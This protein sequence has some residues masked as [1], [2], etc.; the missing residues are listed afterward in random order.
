[1]SAPGEVS[2]LTTVFNLVKLALL[3]FSSTLGISTRRL[4][5][6]QQKVENINDLVSPQG[7]VA[8]EHVVTTKDGYL[9]VVHK[10]EKANNEVGGSGVGSVHSGAPGSGGQ[11]V[12][13]HHGL[14]TNSEL[15]VL[16]TSKEKTLPFL[17]VDM[18][19]E[20]WLGN[21]RGN[22]YS[23]K[24]LKLSS[25]S[26]EFWD[27][28]LDEFAYFD[29]PDT[30]QYIQDYSSYK[31]SCKSQ[32]QLFDYMRQNFE[33][34]S[35]SSTQC[36]TPIPHFNS[37]S[38]LLSGTSNSTG[39]PREI[40]Y[41]GFSQGCSQ[42]IA[43]LALYP[44]LNGKIKQF[45]G[46]SPAIVPTPSPNAIVQLVVE[47]TAMDNSFLYSLFGH[48]AIL[49]S[50]SFWQMMFGPWLYTK[51]VDRSLVTLFGWTGKNISPQQKAKGY[52]YMFSNTSVKSLIHWFQILHAGRFQMFEE[53]GGFGR[54]N[55]SCISNHSKLKGTRVT[56]FPISDHLDVPFM[57]FC[58]DKDILVDADVTR[59]LIVD[60]N[61]KMKDQLEIVMCPG[62]E[63]MDTLWGDEVFQDVF[64][65]ILRKLEDL[66]GKSGA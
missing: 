52:P 12:Y 50:V 25:L 53:T 57:L 66:E 42:L 40:I 6:Q 28:S 21:N 63:H 9:L 8:R 26:A 41:I 3:I 44:S 22:K 59:R 39:P 54:T 61:P 36:P 37:S 13:F 7:Y 4:F 30:L 23:K 47:Q 43:S 31:S 64:S 18:G 32:L 19:Y 48:R 56:P 33:N 60:S 34:D 11:I 24:H 29:I 62:Y 27:F 5:K 2:V 58:G 15:W 49:P 46:L 14:L 51:V 20:V 10:L 55:L 16:G 35:E 1:M 17:L 45:I 65:K 38:T